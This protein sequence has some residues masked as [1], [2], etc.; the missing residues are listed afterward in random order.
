MDYNKIIIALIIILVALVVVGI[1]VLN[2]LTSKTETNVVITS[3]NELN[4]GEQVS[5]TLTDINGT[6][7]ADQ[8]VN[9]TFV[10]ANGGENPQRVVTDGGGN[11]VITLNGLAS[12]QYTVNVIYGGN[13][14]YLNSSTSQQLTIKEKATQ[15]QDAISS[16]EKYKTRSDTSIE[17]MPSGD[18]VETDR[19]GDIVSVNGDPH[20][21][22]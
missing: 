18:I 3:S 7:I 10:D 5:I 12:G 20:A 8:I 9:I 22:Y 6:G 19:F 2:P 15:T 13:D 4:D 11:A 17:V 1:V 14:N 16:L 21:F